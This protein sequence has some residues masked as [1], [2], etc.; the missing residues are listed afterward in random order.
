MADRATRPPS[1]RVLEMGGGVDPKGGLVVAISCFIMKGHTS[2]FD[3]RE[4]GGG[5]VPGAAFP[6]SMAKISAI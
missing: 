5:G 1:S 6:L 3:G 2:N 4:G